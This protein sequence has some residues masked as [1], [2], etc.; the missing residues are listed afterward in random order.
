MINLYFRKLHAQTHTKYLLSLSHSRA[1]SL[2]VE[3]LYTVT[4][5]RNIFDFKY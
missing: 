4:F 5:K 3:Q 2:N 1:Y